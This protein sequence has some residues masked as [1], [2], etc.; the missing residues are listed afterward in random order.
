MKNYR[1]NSLLLKK[2]TPSRQKP[3]AHTPQYP[4]NTDIKKT[5]ELKQ[6]KEI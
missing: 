2:R 3:I 1:D 5:A 6:I 4:E